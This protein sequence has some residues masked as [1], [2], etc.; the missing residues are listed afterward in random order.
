[1]TI[2][3]LPPDPEGENGN[4]ASYAALAVKAFQKRTK[5]DPE[6]VLSDLLGDLMHWADR[7]D[8]DFDRELE[9]ARDHY[10]Y[11]TEEIA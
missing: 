10:R 4:Y 1:M 6:D 9:R 11:E 2:K 3:T 7:N 8:M 5:S